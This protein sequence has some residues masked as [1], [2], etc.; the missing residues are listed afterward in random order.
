MAKKREVPGKAKAATKGP[1]QHSNDERDA[2]ACL[3]DDFARKQ[4]YMRGPKAVVEALSQVMSRRGFAQTQAPQKQAEVWAKAVGELLAKH[5]KAV[6]VSRGALNVVVR[7]S[8]VLM[9]LS[10]R[11][12]ELLGKVQAAAPELKVRDIKLRVG[13]LDG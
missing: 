2:E 10:L 9:E 6:S 7:N 4:R 12:G 8:V 1:F 11:R 3:A 5:S 13:S